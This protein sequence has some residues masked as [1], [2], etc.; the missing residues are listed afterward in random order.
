[1]SLNIKNEEVERLVTE[2]ST[3]TGE[4]K[5]ETVRRALESQRE[6][7]LP[8][9]KREERIRSFL[10]FLQEEVWSGLPDEVSGV[11]LSKAEIEEILGYGPEGV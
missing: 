6:R 11:R 9:V 7:L 5:T 4:G 1:M 8:S 10:R 2:V 3:A